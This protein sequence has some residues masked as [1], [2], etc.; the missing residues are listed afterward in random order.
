VYRADSLA[1][2]RINGP[3]GEKMARLKGKKGIDKGAVVDV[4]EALVEQYLA[5]GDYV[6]DDTPLAEEQEDHGVL[7][8][9]SA[10]EDYSVHGRREAGYDRHGA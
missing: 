5:S 4:P 2:A 9:W 10:D 1:V 7:Q 6:E 3:K 8:E